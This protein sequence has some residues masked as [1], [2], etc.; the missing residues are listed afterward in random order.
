MGGGTPRGDALSFIYM[1]MYMYMYV[2]IYILYNRSYIYVGDASSFY[3]DGQ[4]ADCGHVAAMHAHHLLTADYS[5]VRYAL[6]VC[7]YIYML[8]IYT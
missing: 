8:Y 6:L 3:L 1:Y 7:Y 2:C 5:H 4:N